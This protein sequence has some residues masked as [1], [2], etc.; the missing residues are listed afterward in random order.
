MSVGIIVPIEGW[1]FSPGAFTL[2]YGCKTIAI[3]TA[4]LFLF[5]I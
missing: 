5:S 4:P 3:F 1:V 2:I